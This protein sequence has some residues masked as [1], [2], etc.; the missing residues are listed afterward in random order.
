MAY[1]KRFLA[2]VGLLSTQFFDLSSAIRIPFEHRLSPKR[3]ALNDF[4]RG[5]DGGAVSIVDNGDTSYYANVTIAGTAYSVLLD[6]GSADLWVPATIKAAKSVDLVVN[7]TYAKGSASGHISFAETEFAGYTV[8]DQAFLMVTD[9]RDMAD[10]TTGIMGLGPRANSEVFTTGYLGGS[11]YASYNFETLLDRIFELNLTAS[12]YMTLAAGRD[13]FV[14]TNTI[15][16]VLTIMEVEKGFEKILEAPKNDITIVPVKLT[17]NQHVSVLLDGIIGPDGKEFT[18][19]ST[20]A[21]QS[22]SNPNGK[23][24]AVLDSG[25]TFPQVPKEVADAFYGKV[26]GAEYSEADGV[27]ILPCNAELNVSFVIG[28]IKYPIHPLDTN[29]NLPSFND[30]TI[31]AGIFQPITFDPQGA[32]DLILG[33]AFFRNVY[34]LVNY[35]D[36]VSGSTAKDETAPPYV[37]LL[38]VVDPALAHQDFVNIR[39]GKSTKTDRKSVV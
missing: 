27:W 29:I 13:S 25:F 3:S 1:S 10:P 9:V 34:T 30:T 21:V 5:T 16:Q 20:A 14:G 38:S 33:T 32:F 6:L 15:S 17:G 39:L 31:C 11:K 36:F 22:G 12:N 35:G 4:K 7:L 8:P 23:P 28:G 37:Q 2:G 24:V 18:V 26:K 19:K